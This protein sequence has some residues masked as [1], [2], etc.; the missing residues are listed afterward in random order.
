MIKN[1]MKKKL[2][3]N[4]FITV[5]AIV[6][7]ILSSIVLYIETSYDKSF[8]I[9]SADFNDSSFALSFSTT[10]P[11]YYKARIVEENIP[12][13]STLGLSNWIEVEDIR[14][15]GKS[16]DIFKPGYYTHYF[17]FLEVDKTKK[18]R[19]QIID[20]E[21][22][23]ISTQKLVT[24][25]EWP[26]TYGS[27]DN[28]PIPVSGSIEYE[29]NAVPGALLYAEYNGIRVSTLAAEDG[30][31]VIEAAKFNLT[32]DDLDAMDG[33]KIPLK[34]DL[35]QYG[36]YEEI[37]EL[38]KEEILGRYETDSNLLWAN[39]S[40]QEGSFFYA[41][42]EY[43]ALKR[44]SK[45]VQSVQAEDC[46]GDLVCGV[47]D[48]SR[49]PACHPDK[50]E[51][52]KRIADGELAPGGFPM[53]CV[54]ESS[55][56]K[57]SSDGTPDWDEAGWTDGIPEV[58][59]NTP[60]DHNLCEF[61]CSTACSQ[62]NSSWWGKCG[63][64][65][66]SD[67]GVQTC[68]CEVDD[69]RYIENGY[70]VPK[71]DPNEL[72]VGQGGF[73]CPEGTELYVAGLSNLF[74]VPIGKNKPSTYA[75]NG[76]LIDAFYTIKD[77]VESM[78]VDLEILE[79]GGGI[80]GHYEASGAGT[81][82]DGSSRSAIT[83]DCR[84]PNLENLAAHE[85]Y[86]K[87]QDENNPHR[88]YS[89]FCADYCSLNYLDE[90]INGGEIS[91]WAYNFK[92][93]EKRGQLAVEVMAAHYGVSPSEL[94]NYRDNDCFVDGGICT[95]NDDATSRQMAGITGTNSA[96]LH[97]MNAP[98]GATTVNLSNRGVLGVSTGMPSLG[99]S[100]NENI[101]NTPTPPKN[102]CDNQKSKKLLIEI[103]NNFEISFLIEKNKKDGD[104][105]TIEEYI[106]WIESE[107]ES[108]YPNGGTEKECLI[109]YMQN[110][111]NVLTFDSV[112]IWSDDLKGWIVTSNG[113]GTA[114]F[115][116]IVTQKETPEYIEDGTSNNPLV[117]GGGYNIDG[118]YQIYSPVP[119]DYDTE[120]GT[121]LLDSS[122]I[123]EVNEDIGSSNLIAKALANDP[124]IMQVD[125]SNAKLALYTDTNENN[126][127]DAA[128]E[129][130][131]RV[132]GIP[133]IISKAPET[134]KHTYELT[135][136]LNLIAFP[137]QTENFTAKSLIDKIN[138][139][140]GDALEISTINDGQ[141]QTYKKDD[142]VDY[143]YKDYDLE[144]GK[145]FFVYVGEDSTLDVW[146]YKVDFD[147]TI[148]PGYSSIGF[149]ET[150]IDKYG[151]A[152]GLFEKDTE[153]EEISKYDN[154]SFEIV[155]RQDNI[156]Y[157][158]D[159]PLEEY[160]GYFVKKEVLGV[161]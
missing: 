29:G 53:Q 46:D 94:P 3:W 22:N 131:D 54:C 148:T 121:F 58:G 138:A 83:L 120:T 100:S 51:C 141:W 59:G 82:A 87:Y 50:D 154:N 20:F 15:I 25:G 7:I 55:T 156:I 125:V 13:L 70:S 52:K 21:G 75:V 73:S 35:A 113:T 132:A 103:K 26:E 124:V 72:G 145:S 135:K 39:R 133:I 48:E 6:S 122:E 137:F 27:N 57:R 89:E 160:K 97:A 23:I 108:Y 85:A 155:L 38:T 62:E 1:I 63:Q 90:L 99:N 16:S 24:P 149:S 123:D 109:K 28:K 18:Y 19:V 106:D 151:T 140:G 102:T 143:T 114:N 118:L 136:G 45:F 157:G 127:Y 93:E 31:Y 44:V 84:D 130:I 37:I 112:S 8:N 134:T 126:K 92:T 86:H 147:F 142:T 65:D 41:D 152:Y 10:E 34:V 119:V 98:P 117:S 12:L 88:N 111:P 67:A 115:E 150:H 9:Q 64:K 66:K 128:G 161:Q 71:Y 36:G 77:S 56:S 5:F 79:C 32:E 80:G 2:P 17:K 43:L 144:I 33:V 11:H 69:A 139:Q 78:H 42:D 116:D 14:A 49:G 68:G 61:R 146:G 40:T 129:Q 60:L 4:K 153:I 30:N 101:T 158:N 159:F 107:I 95:N 74:C 76:A 47:A 96:D 81:Y 110:N 91:K 104:I 105:I